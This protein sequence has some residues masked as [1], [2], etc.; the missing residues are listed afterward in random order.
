M[1][2]LFTI[3]AFILCVQLLLAQQP[4][5]LK[6]T[7]EVKHITSIKS[8]KAAGDILWEVTF[9]EASPVWTFG[10]ITGTKTWN[11]TDTT[12]NWGYTNP[13]YQGGSVPVPPLWL[14]MGW[15]Y[16]H[17]YSISGA[18]FAWVDGISDLLG[19]GGNTPQ[20]CNT[21]IQFDGID[22]TGVTAPKLSFYQDYKGFN[23]DHCYIDFSINGGS[24][25]QTLEINQ[26]ITGNAYA[27]P[28][29]ELF[30]G[31]Y[32]ANQSNVSIRLRWETTGTTTSGYGYGW[33]VDDIRIVENALN[34][35]KLVDARM[36][37]FEYVDYTVA[38]QEPYFHSSSH[39][40]MIPNEQFSSEFANMWF[41][42]IFKN[43]G[44]NSATPSF[45]VKVLNPQN[46][47]IF[48]ETVTAT[49]NYTT[50]QID[51]LDLIE[52][53]FSLPTGFTSGRYTIIYN[54]YVTGIEDTNPIDNTDTTYF[55]VSDNV[56]ARDLGNMT[57][58]T[59]PCTWLDGNLDGEMIGTN[60]LFLY[61]T[62]VISM[63]VFI[64]AQTTPGTEIV[65]HVMEYNEADG[66]WFDIS[67]TP[68][69]E[70]QQND[71]GSWVTLTL[72]DPAVIDLAGENGKSIKAAIEFYYGSEDNE[73]W[74][75]VDPTVKDSYWGVSWY[76]LSG[77]SAN[78]WYTFSNWAN[79]GLG[80]R[81]LTDDENYDCNINVNLGDDINQCGGSVTL[82]AGSGFSSYTWNG[83]SGSRYLAVN[84][85][86]SYSVV[87]TDNIGCT[88]SDI[89]NVTINPIPIVTLGDDISQCGGSVTLNA[90]A[91]FSS[92]TW[93]G[94]SGNQIY[95]VSS[96]GQ[97]T[98]LVSNSYGCTASDQIQVNINPIPNVN[99]GSDITQCGGSVTLDAG[100]GFNSYNWNGVAGTRY[101]TVS[102]SGNYTVI[103]GNSYGC[104]ATDA[105]QVTINPAASV[106]LGNDIEQCGGSVTLDAG[107]GF[108]SYTW[109]GVIGTRYKTINSSG[110]YSVVVQNS[111]GC[112]A[113]DAITITINPVPTVSLS[114]TQESN[115]GASDGSA[116]AIATGG[117]PPYQYLWSNDGVGE[118][119]T[120]LT[121]GLYCVQ[122][123]DANGCTATECITVTVSG[124][125]NPP[126]AQF[127][128]DQTEAC[129]SLVVQFTDQST[130]N[131]TVWQWNFG[132]GSPVSNLQH[133]QHNYTTPGTYS[134]S[135]FVENNDGENELVKTNYITVHQ[136][137]SISLS[138]TPATGEFNADGTASVTANTGSAPFEYFWSND[139]NTAN[140][141]GL[142]P[143]EYCVTVEDDNGCIA[144]N[145]ITITYS[146]QA[147]A[148]F[149]AD[150]TEGCS[151]LTVQFTDLSTGSPI[152]WTWNFGD[153][154]TSYEQNP[155]HTYT[156][157]GTYDVLLVA[158]YAD[159]SDSQYFS[160]YIIVN[161]SPEL[162]FEVTPE[163][164]EGAAN[165][166][167][168]LTIVNGTPPYTIN[169][170]NG[171]HTEDIS[172]LTAGVYSVVVIDANDCMVINNATVT[173]FSSVNANVLKDIA[174]YPNPTSTDLTIE[175]VGNTSNSKVEIFNTMGQIVFSGNI[176][177]KTL[178]HTSDFAPGVYL[179]K[180][181]NDQSFVYK[182]FVKE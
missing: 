36:N 1:K 142:L 38:G 144:D 19:A 31:S 166:A 49:N 107:A 168:D 16:V 67:T 73:I 126:T 59:G 75:G 54:I 92:Y 24:S 105:V 2:Q 34:D 85:S 84:S 112:S 172:E 22:L 94:N 95:S 135:L 132:D 134:V 182:K 110:N 180:L 154:S 141:S 23:G 39:Y 14:Y 26:E 121:N 56:F 103:V 33:Q 77:S 64:G 111:Y 93:N 72:A 157:Q 139:G 158:I 164:T 89:I 53:D 68:L 102:T 133:P 99:L 6:I 28:L 74:I 62:E 97:Y 150:E 109:N 138:M 113:T 13:N 86:G 52:V 116:T 177:D 175:L 165:G 51:T 4:G 106:N 101:K 115:N 79:G 131:P 156:L 80:I 163:S 91:G 120:N 127:S 181:G 18:N 171:M 41:N 17:E 76:L 29:F 65:G 46:E 169:W 128:A 35:V 173:I 48:N 30:V 153:G 162:T 3:F 100:A 155:L 57:S 159:G 37:F 136:D 104:T 148:D 143:G 160:E 66:T 43:N 27:A 78:G 11:V 47:E 145:C 167:I 50:S 152:S 130:N 42:G 82:D 125:S 88:A 96:S 90:G 124:Q 140:I 63:D 176:I 114:M 25:W 170:S 12:P 8:A 161:S 44:M 83:A 119:I 15:N 70:I 149:E 117:T 179:I 146:G 108:T 123:S 55:Y 151:P 87:V 122:V 98:V 21:Y 32:I 7:D 137:V 178:V 118:T 71:I 61:N 69:F 40:G 5:D 45:N 20:I 174:I 9:D 129:G 60:Y 81:L 10:Q 147:Y 58:K